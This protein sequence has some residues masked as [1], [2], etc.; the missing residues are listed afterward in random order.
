MNKFFL[1]SKTIIGGLI[2]SLPAI[3]S[4]FGVEVPELGAF[5]DAAIGV[6]DALN[7]GIGLAMVVWGRL[8]ATK[9]LT[10]APGA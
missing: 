3:L 1:T 8:T 2:A 5:G 6:L 9:T 4:A 7:E 10:L